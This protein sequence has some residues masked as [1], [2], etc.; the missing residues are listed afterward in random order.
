MSETEAIKFIYLIYYSLYIPVCLS[1]VI[2]IFKLLKI[3]LYQI[4][5]TNKKRTVSETGFGTS[6]VLQLVHLLILGKEDTLFCVSA[7]ALSFSLVTYLASR[8]FTKNEFTFISCFLI[9]AF[10]AL[11]FVHTN[12]KM[13]IILA[14]T[15]FIPLAVRFDIS[16]IRNKKLLNK[17]LKS[18][19]GSEINDNNE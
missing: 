5:F 13:F 18:G 6:L 15:I 8:F 11:M 17:S 14:Y 19:K 3:I 16:K 7:I 4:I 1:I 10:Y 2:S 12:M 9:G